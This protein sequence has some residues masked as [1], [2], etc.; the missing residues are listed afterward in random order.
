MAP[1]IFLQI[2]R[3]S[4]RAKISVELK[5]PSC[6]FDCDSYPITKK[7]AFCV[8]EFR[9]AKRENQRWMERQTAASHVGN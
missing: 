1:S 5:H 6:G 9:A 8:F 2:K 3:K 4:F 7:K